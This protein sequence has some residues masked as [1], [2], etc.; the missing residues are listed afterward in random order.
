MILLKY[1]SS[2]KSRQFG[3]L[4]FKTEQEAYD[5]VEYFDNTFIDTTKIRVELAKSVSIFYWK[6]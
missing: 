1:Y 3:F 4:G 6:M 2:G 5:S